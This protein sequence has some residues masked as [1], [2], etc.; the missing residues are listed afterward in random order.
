[1]QKEIGLLRRQ[2]EASQAVEPEIRHSPLAAMSTGAESSNQTAFM[3]S[4]VLELP[5]VA[6]P[7]TSHTSESVTMAPPTRQTR[8]HSIDDFVLEP[9]KINDCID[10]SVPLVPTDEL[11]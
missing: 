8:E 2:V 5:Q 4:A 3:E 6:H 11:R 1:M 7:A 9:R 10:L